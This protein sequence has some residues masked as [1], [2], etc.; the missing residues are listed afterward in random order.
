M[1]AKI[2][3]NVHVLGQ[4]YGLVQVNEAWEA[5]KA[6]QEDPWADVPV[7]ISI[8][9]ER[10]S[11]GIYL[12]QPDEAA[13]ANTF[14]VTATPEFHESA[15]P[16]V[17]IQY[18][19]RLRL[20]SSEPWVKAPKHVLLLQS[21][22]QFAVQVDPRRLTPGLHVAFVRAYDE[23]LPPERGPVFQV[24]VTVVK[25]ELISPKTTTLELGDVQF[26]EG[27]RRRWFLVPPHG[28]TVIEVKVVDSRS[29]SRAKEA[30]DDG[31]DEGSGIGAIDDANRTVVLHALQVFRGVPYRD[32]EHERYIQVRRK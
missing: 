16:D 9:S 6:L 21:G 2:L 8:N 19:V 7:S 25:P 12:R 22:K 18:E 24:P 17:K 20:E 31:D 3:P 15:G 23:S 26:N 29:P 1:Q 27:E 10:F 32:N 30:Q 11:R 4:G 28:C 5:L 13:T 14:S